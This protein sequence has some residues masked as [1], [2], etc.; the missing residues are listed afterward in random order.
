[1]IDWSAMRDDLAETRIQAP[2]FS[3][4]LR[5]ACFQVFTSACCPQMETWFESFFKVLVFCLFVFNL[6]VVVVAVMGV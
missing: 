6:A 2:A 5:M 3:Q 1:M 4:L